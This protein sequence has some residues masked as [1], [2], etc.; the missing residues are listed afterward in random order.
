[1]I[2][3]PYIIAEIGQAHDGSLGTAHAYI[4]AV[5][6]THASAIKFQTHYAA[7]E[8]SLDEPW[9]VKFS[10]QDDT[11][12]EYWR[13]ME[14]TPA[15]W[16]ELGIHA[17]ECGLDYISSPFSLKAV[18]VL[19]GA[20]IDAWKIPSGE[21]NNVLML[22]MISKTD[23][24]IF[25]ST[26]MSDME[27][28]KRAVD[29]LGSEG[30]ELIVMQ[31]TTNYPVLAEKL[32][33][34]LIYELAEQFK[35]P[36][37]LSDHSGNIFS[38][39]AAFSLGAV[40]VEVHVTLSNQAFGPDVPASITIQELKQLVEGARW[41]NNAIKNPVNKDEIFSEFSESRRI[42]MKSFAARKKINKGQTI[43]ITDLV[44]KKPLKGI[45]ASAPERVLGKKASR[46]IAK[47]AFIKIDDIEN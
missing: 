17:K 6:E 26:G 21:V 20:D 33:L 18:D 37:G 40:A 43:E 1:M 12:Y 31:C 24:P 27:E 44:V 15:Q 30:S 13:R 25:L 23:K 14:F 4:D 28:I 9:R 35:L 32:G 2:E 7:E 29:I 46:E 41:I 3:E 36:A 42:F 38:S 39:L 45:P 19:L 11:R 47:G 10:T 5:A 16:V 22:E 34:N 8:S